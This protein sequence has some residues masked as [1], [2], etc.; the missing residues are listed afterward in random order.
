MYSVFSL[1]FVGNLFVCG[2]KEELAC[3]CCEKFNSH[4]E[5]WKY[6]TF[7]IGNVFDFCL[8][9]TCTVFLLRTFY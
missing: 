9:F 7:F 1:Q 5:A 6:L 3:A 8:K 4:D 2:G